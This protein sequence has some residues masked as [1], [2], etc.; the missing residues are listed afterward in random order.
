MNILR[1]MGFL[2]PQGFDPDASAFFSAAGITDGTQK[3][4]INTL[5]K[6]LKAANLWTKM[7]AIYPL[8]GG[9]ATTCKYNLKD[10]RDL[11]AAF[12]LTFLG[13]IQISS[14]GIKNTT[15]ANIGNGGGAADTHFYPN[16]FGMY[17]DD[18]HLSF[19]SRT[20]NS[21]G[22][23]DM[24]GDNS[25]NSWGCLIYGNNA[26]SGFNAA[27]ASG[28]IANSFGLYTACS[29]SSQIAIY[30]NGSKLASTTPTTHALG[31]NFPTYLTASSR[32]V[33]GET[34]TREFAYA[35]IG[36][37][38]TDTDVANLYTAVQAFQTTLGRQV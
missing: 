8:V 29:T 7:V 21:N 1:L 25:G 20:N 15:T 18:V 28:S 24:S 32:Q 23:Y 26:Y 2:P 31:P 5:V 30:K 38:L 19:Y 34:S 12:R 3:S 27:Y 14:T 13:T 6:D 4:A 10:P 37:G 17:Y 16:T 22:S 9:T 35:S 36:Y 33:N 11:D